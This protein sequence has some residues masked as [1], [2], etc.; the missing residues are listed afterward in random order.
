MNTRNQKILAIVPAFNECGNIGRTVSEIHRLSPGIDVL[1]INDGSSD[2]TPHEAMEAG[3]KVISLPFN[4]GIGAAVQTGFKYAKAHQYDIAVQIDGDGQHDP[5]FVEQ[6]IDP[7][8]RREADMVV[9]SRFLEKNGYQSSFSR[10]IGI[11]FFVHLINVLTGAN[12]TDPTSGF[13]AYGKKLINLFS[14]YY[15]YDF[16]EPEAIVVTQQAG[17]KIVELPVVMRAREAGSSS[18]RYFKTLYYMM[19]VTLAILLHMIRQRPQI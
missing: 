5:S 19:K 3:A 17:G 14:E 7:I 15:P 8:C 16:P 6:L 4:L 10:R 1:V 13:R 11:N 12:I 18:I 2:D 9:G